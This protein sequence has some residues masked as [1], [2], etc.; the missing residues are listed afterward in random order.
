M[1]VEDI[2]LLCVVMRRI[3]F[4]PNAVLQGSSSNNDGEVVQWVWCHNTG[5]F[6]R[7]LQH[8]LLKLRKLLR[9]VGV[10]NWPLIQTYDQLWLNLMRLWWL[11]RLMMGKSCALILAL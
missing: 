10:F 11:V 7:L 8:T 2:G 9:S 4:L 1:K 5:R 6:K 3:S